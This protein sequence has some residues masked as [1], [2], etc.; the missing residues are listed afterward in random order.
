MSTITKVGST[1][2]EHAIITSGIC[3]L[4]IAPS[5]TSILDKI[6]LSTVV[7]MRELIAM[8]GVD[9]VDVQLLAT[10]GHRPISMEQEPIT[11]IGTSISI[12]LQGALTTK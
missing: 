7:L 5:Q 9:A 8:E 3:Q 10:I 2:G 4:Q 1:L 12:T 11:N 6:L